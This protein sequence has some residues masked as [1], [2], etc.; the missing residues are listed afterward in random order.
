MPRKKKI[1]SVK[2]LR[3]CC[4]KCGGIKGVY[5]RKITCRNTKQ[6]PTCRLRKK[7]KKTY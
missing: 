5:K 4:T 6:S 7:R 3:G 2:N 1:K